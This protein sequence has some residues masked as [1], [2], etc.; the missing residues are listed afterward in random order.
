MTTEDN[1]DTPLIARSPEA[2]WYEIA[3]AE[4]GVQEA[5]GLA[6]NPRVQEYFG[7]VGLGLNA[8]DSVPWCSAFVNWCLE[9]AGMHGTGKPN[10]R[11]FLRWGEPL[12]APIRGAICVFERPPNVWNG[13]VAFYA[14]EGIGC[15]YV[16]GGNQGNRVCIAPYAKARLLGVRWPTGWPR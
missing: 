1:A 6:N 14:S 7:A 13:H 2:P 5:P 16:L 10:A 12:D 3:L 8:Q 11:S 4:L 15:M 9:R